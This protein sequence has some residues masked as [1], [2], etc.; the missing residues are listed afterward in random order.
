[1]DPLLISQYVSV[2][3]TLLFLTIA[4]YFDLKTREVSDKVWVVYAPIGLALTVFRTYM[5]PSLLILTVASIA[6]SVL[7]G[8]GLVFFGL[9]GGADAKALMCLGLTLPL[10]PGI[11]NPILGYFHPFFPIV[12]L[13][14]GYICS[15]S[16]AIWML[17]RNLTLLG[18]DHSAM[19][20]G[21]E[22][23]PLWKEA[24][25][26]TSGYRTTLQRLQSTFYLYPMEKVVED[27]SGVR[28]TLQLYANADVDREEEVARFRESL[29]K[30]GSPQTVWVTPGLPLLLFILLAVLIVLV[31]GDPIFA[32]LSV[33]IPH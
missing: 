5:V 9:S 12:V 20:E 22:N 28:R 24:L 7:V 18:F 4:A 14:T 16:V 13:I 25:A 3:V 15:L 32:V 11:M 17:A 6:L 33:I 19:F 8:F 27:S 26:L 23:E 1:M 2:A 31:L 30:V 21:L 10:P 29:G